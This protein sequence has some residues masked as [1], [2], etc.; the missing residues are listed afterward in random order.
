MSLNSL[1]SRYNSLSE[2]WGKTLRTREEGTRP[3]AALVEAEAP[4][5]ERL[6]ARGRIARADAGDDEMR[7]LYGRFV[8]AR[9]RLEAGKAPIPYERFVRGIARESDRLR[10]SA[11]CAEIEL[12]VVVAHDK[13]HVKARP[14]RT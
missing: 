6:V 5:G 9:S 7:R 13:V 11:G 3:A 14:G 12:R 8:E 1:I 2:L 4:R 10:K